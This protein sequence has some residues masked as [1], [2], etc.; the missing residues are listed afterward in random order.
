MCLNRVKS[1]A[2]FAVAGSILLLCSAL[3]RAEIP[4]TIQ[5]Q[6]TQESESWT[7]ADQNFT[8]TENEVELEYNADQGG[9]FQGKHI[10]QVSLGSST[11]YER[12][13]CMRV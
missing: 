11:S 1:T 9:T 4:L 13:L 6:G 2:S 10:R 3:V 7:S 8:K 5:A 12:K